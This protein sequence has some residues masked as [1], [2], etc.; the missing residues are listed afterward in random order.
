MERLGE[1][2]ILTKS[3]NELIFEGYNDTLLRIARKMKATKLPYDKFAWFYAVSNAWQSPM[4]YNSSEFCR[5]NFFFNFLQRNNSESYDGTFSIYTGATDFYKMGITKEWNFK[6]KPEFYE[7][8]CGVIDGS[9]G[10]LWP[11]LTNNK[12][13]SI[14]IPDICTW[15]E[16]ILCSIR[17]VTFAYYTGD[18]RITYGL[19]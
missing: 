5:N 7:G 12:T 11:P 4:C 2:L 1:K 18:L 17:N 9:L 6:S 15:V 16:R 3:V 13:V 10:D 14:F 19:F 8:S